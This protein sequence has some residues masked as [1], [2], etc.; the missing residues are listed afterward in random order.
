M[1]DRTY[2]SSTGDLEHRRRFRAIMEVDD[3]R[4]PREEDALELR[5]ELK[6][7]MKYCRCR[8]PECE[9]C[10]PENKETEDPVESSG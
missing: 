7:R 4:T 2:P 5:R 10:Y 1:T 8:H 3:F 6:K 9:D